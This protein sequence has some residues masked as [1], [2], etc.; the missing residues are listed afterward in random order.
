MLVAEV[1]APEPVGPAVSDRVGRGHVNRPAGR[2]PRRTLVGHGLSEGEHSGPLFGRLFPTG[3]KREQRDDQS[4]SSHGNSLHAGNVA[5]AAVVSS[6]VI[7]SMD[8][9]TGA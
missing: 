5:L 1:R 9:V 4:K 3:S 2:R 7:V 6:G 8:V